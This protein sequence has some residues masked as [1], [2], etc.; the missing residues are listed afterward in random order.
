MISCTYVATTLFSLAITNSAAV[1][2]MFPVALA[3]ASHQKLDF[4][5]FAY[6]LMMAASAGFMTPT[7]CPT[8]LMVYNPGSYKFSDYIHYGGPLQVIMI[9]HNILGDCRLSFLD[10]FQA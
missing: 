10:T 5:P 9:Y 2:I 8:N 6:T 1:T 3:A 7:A 4:R